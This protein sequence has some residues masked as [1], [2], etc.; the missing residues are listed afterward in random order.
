MTP[1]YEVIAGMWGV[2]G[3]LIAVVLVVWAVAV[4]PLRRSYPTLARMGEEW[5]ARAFLF[6]FVAVFAVRYVQAGWW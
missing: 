1:W 3:V 5:L 2:A 4:R 6:A